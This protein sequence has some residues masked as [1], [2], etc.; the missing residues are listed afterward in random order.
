MRILAYWKRPKDT[1]TLPSQVPQERQ[2]CEKL[3]ALFLPS[4]ERHL[5]LFKWRAGNMWCRYLPSFLFVPEVEITLGFSAVN[6]FL[7]KEKGRETV[8][9]ENRELLWLWTA[10]LSPWGER[11]SEL[12]SVFRVTPYMCVTQLYPVCLVCMFRGMSR[13]TFLIIC[14]LLSLVSQC[15]F[16]GR[17]N[18]AAAIPRAVSGLGVAPL[19]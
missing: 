5:S 4:S 13:G 11:G 12:K 16:E 17:Q 10:C 14:F 8:C 2:I 19:C 18:K 15:N 1:T 3:G 7:K 9:G 6:P